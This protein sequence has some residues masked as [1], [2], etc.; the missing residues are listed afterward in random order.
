MLLY[1]ATCVLVARTEVCRDKLVVDDSS[2]DAAARAAAV[3]VEA[4]GNQCWGAGSCYRFM[5]VWL[6]KM[7]SAFLCCKNDNEIWLPRDMQKLVWSR[8]IAKTVVG[9]S[10]NARKSIQRT[11]YGE[12]CCLAGGCR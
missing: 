9:N 10:E 12:G 11:K 5:L 6:R 4:I 7:A 2:V 1:D 8:N 3:A